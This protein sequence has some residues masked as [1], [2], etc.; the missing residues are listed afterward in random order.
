ML[1]MPERIGPTPACDQRSH[2]KP[3]RILP[4]VTYAYRPLGSSERSFT[5]A[6]LKLLL[7]QLDHGIQC[8]ALEP[9]PLDVQPS[10]P[11]LFRDRDVG[12]QTVPVE[13]D[14]R[15]ESIPTAVAE[16]RLEPRHV[17]RDCARSKRYCFAIGD[18]RPLAEDTA[19]SREGLA[20]ILSRLGLEMRAPQQGHELVAA[21]WFRGRTGQKG[22]Y[23]GQ[24]LAGQIDRAVRPGQFKAAEQRQ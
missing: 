8:Q 3:M 12:Q 13:A 14:R 17:R 1:I 24:L 15:I 6:D 16:Q 7:A 10:T 20:Q 19:Q 18:Q 2:H 22:Q 11:A 23:A 21:L 9:L 4:N 5:M